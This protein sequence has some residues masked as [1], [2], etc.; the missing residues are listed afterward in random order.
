[1]NGIIY[2]ALQRTGFQWQLEKLATTGI[3]ASLKGHDDDIL[4]VI[5]PMAERTLGIHCEWCTAQGSLELLLNLIL[6]FL[7]VN[8]TVA[9]NI[10]IN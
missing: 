4:T 5:I 2:A 7:L 9:L 6:A 1:M 8:Q 10:L 3:K